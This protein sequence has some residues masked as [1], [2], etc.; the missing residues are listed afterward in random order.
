MLRRLLLDLQLL[1]DPTLLENATVN[2]MA[3]ERRNY[4]VIKK[5]GKSNY[6][7]T[8]TVKRSRSV[9]QRIVA[10]V[11]SLGS[12]E[13]KPQTGRP[14]KSSSRQYC[15]MVR[16]SLKG[17]FKSAAEIS[18]KFSSISDVNVSRETVS[19]RSQDSGCL[20][21]HQERNL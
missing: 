16:L 20:L 9:V 12:T 21:R 6:V 19:M 3:C 4:L 1:N 8:T 14:H 11:M 10:R 2:K 18:C 5:E 13:D 17:R 7:V 15:I